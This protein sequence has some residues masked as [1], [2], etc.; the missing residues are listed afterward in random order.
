MKQRIVKSIL[1]ATLTAAMVVG[2]MPTAGWDIQAATD[3]ATAVEEGLVIEESEIN[4]LITAKKVTLPKAVSGVSG[5]SITYSVSEN[6][7]KYV[8]VDGNKLEITRPYA[9]EGNCEFDLTATVTA[10]DGSTYS[11]KFP[12]TIREGLSD[13]SLAGYLYVSF[14][15]E[16]V[17]E[18]SDVQQLHFF[19]S[20]DGLNWTAVNGCNPVFLTGEDYASNIVSCGAGS[21]NYEV[22]PGTDIT[23]T[24]TGDASVLFPFEGDDQGVRDPY[25]IRGCK[26]DGSDAGKTWILATDLNTHD[27]ENYN[28]NKLTNTCGNWGLTNVNG[29]SSLFV[30]ET[31]DYVNWTRRYIDVGIEVDGEET[32]CMAWAPEAIYNPAKDNYLVYWSARTTVDG[33]ARDRVYCN[34]TDDFVTFGPTKLYEQDAFYKNYGTSGRG[35]N[36]GYGTIDTSMLWVADEETG[37][38]YGTLFRVTKDETNNHIELYS[39]DT[40]LDPNVDYDASEAHKIASYE[41]DGKTYASL[42]DLATIPGDTND[43]K[44]ADI[45][46]NWFK[47][48]ATGN[49]FTKISQTGIEQYSGAYE[50]ATMFKFIDRDEWCVMIDYYGSMKVRYEP[51]TTTDLSNPDS[52]QKVTSGYGRTGGDIGTH[53]GMIPITVK[54]YNTIIDTYNADSTVENY[55]KISYIEVDKSELNN[56]VEALEKAVASTEYTD[57]VKAQMTNLV[58]KAEAVN[59]DK[60]A[61]SDEVAQVVA[62]ADK[63]INNVKL[64][65]P[66]ITTT[67]G[68]IDTS[69]SEEMPELPAVKSTHTI[70]KVKYQVTSVDEYNTDGTNGTVTV[71]GTTKKKAT[72]VV[73][74]DEIEIDGYTFAVNKIANN[75][76]KGCSKLK[77]ITIGDNV[78]SIGKN[79]FK[80]IHKKATFKV[81]SDNYDKVKK[82]LKSK[83][84]FKKPMK[85]QEVSE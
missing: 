60:G 14:A 41:L 25:L 58:A 49:H 39:S 22:A 16:R 70:N 74:P 55:H 82:L 66:T 21:V 27:A 30:W 57:A 1:A 54:E 61:S 7:S 40:V 6:A 13:D 37:N 83:V 68:D 73:I 63:L 34:E 45:V 46:W 11:K 72:S 53:G 76:F 64:S 31:E 5:A 81:S 52:I 59:K 3:L 56:K 17:N 67:P 79:A 85:I 12:M 4:Q 15:V 42:D 65:V 69:N 2:M 51:Y 77:K 47:D 50:G 20:E 35:N 23:K 36:S 71:T 19:L 33:K 28:G 18:A 8:K 80:G 75:A 24:V 43:I 38:P 44:R 62:R 29:S 26:P 48:N 9:G 78:K 84:G 10:E 32:I